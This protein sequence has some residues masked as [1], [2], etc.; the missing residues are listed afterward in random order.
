MDV[1][2]RV[3]VPCRGDPRP[4]QRHPSVQIWTV[5][6]WVTRI[7]NIWNDD[8]RRRFK[9]V[10]TVICVISVGFAVA[11]WMVV[12][13]VRRR[14]LARAAATDLGVTPESNRT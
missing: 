6:V 1:D 14:T 4:G 10:H 13:Q 2:P 7:W 5:Y 9:A 12:S 11:A 8:P 3:N